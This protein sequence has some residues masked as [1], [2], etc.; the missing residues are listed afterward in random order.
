MR[1]IIFL[2]ILGGFFMSFNLAAEEIIW[3]EV[4]KG[5]LNINTI[6]LKP[7]HPHII[8]IGTD[9]GVLKSQDGGLTWRYIFLMQG[10]N[11]GIN[12]LLFDP[13]DKV[14]LYAASNNGLYYSQNDGI[15]WQRIFKGKNILE[16][17]VLCLAILS[18]RIYLGTNQGLFVSKDKGLSWHKYPG[19][20]GNISILNIAIHPKDK[21]LYVVGQD[22]LY[23]IEGEAG[24]DKRIFKRAKKEEENYQEEV[25]EEIKGPSLFLVRSLGFD[26]HNPDIL[27]LATFKG[28]YKSQDKGRT[29]DLFPSEGLISLDIRFI[30]V[31]EDSELYVLT[32]KGIFKYRQNKWEDLSFGLF[33]KEFKALVLDRQ[34]NLWVVS[35]KGLFKKRTAKTDKDDGLFG[36]YLQNEPTISQVQQAAIEYAEVSNEKIKDWRRQARRSAW[37]PHL[38]VSIERD[39]TDLWHWETGSTTKNG[40]D[41]LVRGRAAIEWDITLSWDLSRLIWNEDQ[42]NIDVRSRLMVELRQEILDE[43]NKLYF[44]RLRTKME[45]ENIPWQE[46]RKRMEKEL[47]LKELTASLDALTGG[48]FSQHLR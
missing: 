29:W 25:L 46:K 33:A 13:E 22:G 47:R 31:S 36:L 2:G 12:F 15:S 40:D 11:K 4:V 43:V 8:Y 35:D 44:E 26:P 7:D 14:S 28:I 19:R 1:K 48:Y 41:L 16:N 23:K 34:N 20:L 5:N 3:E 32:K 9:K 18:E 39:I 38:S 6:L 17:Q 45:L 21:Q 37:L 10:K 42:T 24:L 30:L 27:Y